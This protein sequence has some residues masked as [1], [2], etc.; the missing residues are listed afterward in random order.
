MR[1]SSAE[2]GVGAP[3]APP[4][5]PSSYCSSSILIATRYMDCRAR[6][7]PAVA[8]EHPAKRRIPADVV[9]RRTSYSGE[10]R[11]AAGRKGGISCWARNAS[12]ARCSVERRAMSLCRRCAPGHGPIGVPCCGSRHRGLSGASVVLGDA[13]AF[14]FSHRPAAPCAGPWRF[15]PLRYVDGRGAWP[16]PP[17]SGL[18]STCMPSRAS[19]DLTHPAPFNRRRR[20]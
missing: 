11:M 16:G 17:C 12:S 3:G 10:G 20:H 19:S 18:A 5:E 6:L 9:F 1:T 15:C 14:R 13:V 7:M 2:T 4:V 8:A